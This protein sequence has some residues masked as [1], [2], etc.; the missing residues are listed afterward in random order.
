MTEVVSLRNSSINI[1][2]ITKRKY[3]LFDRVREKI[4]EFI[5]KS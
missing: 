5:Y 2:G 4:A 3:I 1:R